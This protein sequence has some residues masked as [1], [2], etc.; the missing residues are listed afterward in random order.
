MTHDEISR[1]TKLSFAAA[2]K[3]LMKKKPLDKITVTELVNECDV[4]RKTFYYHF[5]N[6][7]DLVSWILDEEAIKIIGQFDLTIDLESAT[8][9]IM[10]YI[11]DNSDMLNSMY[12]SL[13]RESVKRFLHNNMLDICKS[14]IRLHEEQLHIT[15]PDLYRNILSEFYTEGLS[16]LMIY[17]LQKGKKR[18]KER[19]IYYITSMVQASIVATL[20]KFA[21]ETTRYA[22]SISEPDDDYD[23]D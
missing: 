5:N 7:E 3:S 9:F 4:N 19:I 15:L 1:N 17:W 23:D 2:L 20:E 16:S 6:I 13:G 10:D 11:S 12:S 8:R 21:S 14:T 18:N 22:P